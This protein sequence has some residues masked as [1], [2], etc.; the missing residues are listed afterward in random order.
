M[1]E[2]RPQETLPSQ[3]QAPLFSEETE[4][5]TARANVVA[6]FDKLIVDYPENILYYQ[7]R[8]NEELRKI[9]EYFLRQASEAP[10]GSGLP[11]RVIGWQVRFY[12]S[13]FDPQ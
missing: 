11:R 12:D 7:E 9:Q 4:Y 3:N 5:A 13:D 6:F 10:G 1:N 2:P 8:R